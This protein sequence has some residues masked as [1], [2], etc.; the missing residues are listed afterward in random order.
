VFLPF[1][2]VAELRAGFALGRRG[3][4]NERVLRRFGAEAAAGAKR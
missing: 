1:I 4:E 3:A 2:V